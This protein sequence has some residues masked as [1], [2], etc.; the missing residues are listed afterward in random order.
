[1]CELDALN[2]MLRLT[3]P[4]PNWSGRQRVAKEIRAKEASAARV[5]LTEN[6]LP[7]KI[8]CASWTLLT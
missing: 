7:I 6:Y 8:R 4:A 2:M 1:M 5:L 3:P